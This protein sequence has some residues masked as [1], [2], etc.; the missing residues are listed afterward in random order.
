MERVQRSSPQVLL[1]VKED[2]KGGSDLPVFVAF[3]LVVYN[4]IYVPTISRHSASI[5]VNEFKVCYH[6]PLK[7]L[8]SNIF[9]VLLRAGR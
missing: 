3:L 7:V 1:N 6:F 8:K 4:A 2:L 5:L 9:C